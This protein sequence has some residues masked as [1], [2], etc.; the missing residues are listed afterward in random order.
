M[1]DH[2]ESTGPSPPEAISVRVSGTGC[3]TAERFD[4]LRRGAHIHD[5][6]EEALA[7]HLAKPCFR[8]LR[9]IASLDTL[10]GKDDQLLEP[11]P[12]TDH[13]LIR[14]LRTL[15]G[16]PPLSWLQVERRQALEAIRQPYGFL[17]LIFEESRQLHLVEQVTE[18]EHWHDVLQR[19]ILVRE[20]PHEPSLPA[21]R[22]SIRANLY[23][24][25]ARLEMGGYPFNASVLDGG[26]RI[27]RV[28]SQGDFLSALGSVIT[29]YIDEI[30]G[31]GRCNDHY[32]QAERRLYLGGHHERLAE[33][34]L[35][36]ARARLRHEDIE[37]TRY[38]L[39][40]A[41]PLIEDK[42]EAP[43]LLR[44]LRQLRARITLAEVDRARCD[45]SR[46]SAVG[47][48][49]EAMADLPTIPAVFDVGLFREEVRLRARMEAL[50]E[51][52][53]EQVS[54]GLTQPDT[55]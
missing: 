37:G 7:Q 28:D 29:A 32:R 5:S 19:V 24:A 46:R 4:R 41:A 8:C 39:K 34:V 6:F 20:N 15:G 26:F 52:G 40:R 42:L 13:P 11:L 23:L 47:R 48:F 1:G 50:G 17:R 22:L 45:A 16:W 9:R 54:V 51:S 43:L 12:D 31:T 14:A 3:Q 33:V 35:L 36:H 44:S 53:E 2:Q 21:K 10:A 25:E 30:S 18:V 27:H 38:E 49:V 55:P